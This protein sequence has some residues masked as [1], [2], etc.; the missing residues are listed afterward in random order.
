MENKKTT[1]EKTE[2]N[3]G[4]NRRKQGSKQ[5]KIGRKQKN[6]GE[7]TGE[8]RGGNRRKQVSKQWRKQEKTGEKIVEKTGKKTEE[9]RGE[10]RSNGQK[11]L[12]LRIS[13]VSV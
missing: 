12:I 6:T 3:R 1:G 5:K 4:V 9:N 13:P 7:K 11:V 2:E 8:N 10:T